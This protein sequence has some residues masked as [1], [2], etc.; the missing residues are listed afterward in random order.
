MSDTN[1]IFCKIADKDI[2]SEIIYEDEN[3]LAFLDIHPTAPGHTLLIPKD[4]YPWFYEIPTGLAKDL[5]AS[6]Q[7]VAKDL[8]E[9]YQSDYVEL[10]II[11]IDIPHTHVHLIPRQ[12]S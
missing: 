4:H 11:G 7:K 9:K 1:C 10:K 8:K 2:P 5:F 6:A 3:F 12:T